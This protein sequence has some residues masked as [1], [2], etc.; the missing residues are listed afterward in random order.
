ML[1]EG[2]RKHRD[3]SGHDLCWF[4]PELWNLLPEKK[5]PTPDVPP[6]DEFMKQCAVYRASLGGKGKI[7]HVY[8]YPRPSVTV[9]IVVIRPHDRGHEMLFIRRKNDP[10]KGML[11]L[12]GGFVEMNEG[13]QR[14]ALRELQEETGVAR[15]Q[16]RN[17]RQIGAYGAPKRDPR[18]R[19]ISVAF[20]ANVEVG[21]MAL[22]AD[23]AAEVEW[24]DTLKLLNK[25]KMLDNG[26]EFAFDHARVVEDSAKVGR[27]DD[28]L[29]QWELEQ[30]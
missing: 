21:T 11:A 8:E 28:A 29:D 20:L 17:F 9:D 14:A 7:P 25:D 5:N 24:V 19:V 6:W 2:I 26:L 10:F 30:E 12:P 27:D 13:L 18:G 1:R 22:P 16:I 15:P 23:D 4:H 3:S